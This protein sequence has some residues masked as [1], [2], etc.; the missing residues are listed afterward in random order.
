MTWLESNDMDTHI[1]V[2][3]AKNV[4]R[5]IDVARLNDMTKPTE[6]AKAK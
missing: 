4:A 2:A 1:K 6:F 3:K 5:P